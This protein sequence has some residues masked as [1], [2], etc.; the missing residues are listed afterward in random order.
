MFLLPF[1]VKSWERIGVKAVV[2]LIGKEAAFNIDKRSK[3]TIQILNEMGTHIIYL[4][5][6]RLSPTSLSQ[7]GMD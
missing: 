3:E 6:E 4:Q 5:P 1:T 7:V 2:I